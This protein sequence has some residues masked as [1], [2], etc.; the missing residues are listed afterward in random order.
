MKNLKIKPLTL[1]Q[2]TISIDR[3]TRFKQ[4]ETKYLR[5]YK[6]IIT[7]N[8]IQP[9]YKRK[10]LDE[11]DY[12][13]LKDLAETIINYSLAELKAPFDNDFTIN[14]RLYDYENSIFNLTEPVLNLLKNKI[15][16]KGFLTLVDE[17]NHDLPINLKWLFELSLSID[18]YDERNK[19][20]LHF[21]IEKIVICEGIT[22][23]T[24]LPVFAKLCGFDFDKN[25]IHIL[26]AGGKNQVVK[27]FYKLA[28]ELKLPIFILLDSDAEENLKEIKPRLRD[29][30]K[31]HIL[32]SGE[33]ED[34]LGK[35]LVEK[36]LNYT[37]KNISLVDLGLLNEDLPMVK[38]LEEIFKKRGLHEFKKSEFAELVKINIESSDDL[39]NEIKNIIDEIKYKPLPAI[40]Q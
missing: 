32:K 10:E 4:T 5:V 31:V 2:L 17:K 30:D 27:T 38:I 25:G 14:Q 26:S 29:F 23:E 19:K 16:Y 24:L 35:N 13:T 7:N 6:D 20:S 3:L 21:P 15:N 33:F 22:E 12:K 9:K 8:L 36:T 11:T 40:K 28:D 18:I 39:S 34:L 1:E 37:F